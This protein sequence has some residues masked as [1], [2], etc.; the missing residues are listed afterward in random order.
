MGLYQFPHVIDKR[1]HKLTIKIGFLMKI[2]CADCR[3]EY[4]IYDLHCTLA[5]RGATYQCLNH[6]DKLICYRCWDRKRRK[7]VTVK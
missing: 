7:D 4:Y 5:S 3:K 6:K 2:K 1:H